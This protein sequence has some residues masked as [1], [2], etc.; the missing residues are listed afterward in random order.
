MLNLLELRR[1][2]ERGKDIFTMPL[3]VTYYARVSSLKDSQLNSLDNQMTFFEN[4]IKENE[5]WTLVHGYV[6][7]G[8]GRVWL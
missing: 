8:C 2:F 7:E 4:Y 6:D 5:N 3:R 1:N